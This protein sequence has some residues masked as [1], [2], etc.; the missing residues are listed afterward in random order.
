MQSRFRRKT[1]P[2]YVAEPNNSNRSGSG[3]EP[4]P[5]LRLTRN[6]SSRAVAAARAD[7]RDVSDGHRLPASRAG[8]GGSA[9]L[10]VE[11]RLTH[12]SPARHR[13]TNSVPEVIYAK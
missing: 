3:I 7:G 8:S 13:T 4:L 2:R 1:P 12:D 9:P 11:P 10:A 5:R 6:G